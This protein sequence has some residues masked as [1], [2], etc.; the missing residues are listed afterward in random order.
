M[1]YC[2][3]QGQ[4][5]TFSH[6]FSKCSQMVISRI[7]PGGRWWSCHVSAAAQT[8]LWLHVIKV[9]SNQEK[10]KMSSHWNCISVKSRSSSRKAAISTHRTQRAYAPW[11]DSLARIR[12]LPSLAALERRSSALDRVILPWH[13]GVQPDILSLTQESELKSFASALQNNI[14]RQSQSRSLSFSFWLFSSFHGAYVSVPSF[15]CSA[16]L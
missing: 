1:K 8:Q 12:K 10:N 9:C 16:L 5:M 11:M 3:T 6:A 14:F 15:T 13:Q 2:N 4:N 7:I